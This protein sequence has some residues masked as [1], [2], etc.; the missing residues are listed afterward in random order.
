LTE[1]REHDVTPS[2]AHAPV[3]L[4]A[5][6]DALSLAPNDVVLDCTF[7]RGGHTRAM[8][9]KL[10]PT[11][12]VYA[13]DRD[14]DAVAHGERVKREDPRLEIAHC[15]FSDL[16]GAL[17]TLG[18][19]H[20]N[21]ILFDLGVSSPQLDDGTRGFSFVRNGPLDMRMDPSRGQSAEEWLAH[22]SLRDLTLTLTNLGEERFA[23]RIASAIVRARAETA[24]TTT[25]ELA[26][27]VAAA[28]PKREV[29]K[30]P[31]TRSFQ[32]I[33]MVVNDEL[34]QLRSGLEGA[35]ECLAVGGRIAAISF[36]SLEDRIVK[37]FMREHHRGP[38]LPRGLP[39]PADWPQP[40]LVAVAKPVKAGAAEVAA[41]PRARSAILRVC[42]KHGS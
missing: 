28:V 27:I 2:Q 31:A 3:L 9:A 4:R 36:H 7:G 20:V 1:R 26:D 37:H 6:V 17:D 30:H 11:G 25:G 10:G 18:V 22:V 13:L 38:E 23:R 34:G 5:A 32:A 14:P 42:R 15:A 21:A 12:R 41:N 35:L 39:A 40:E 24:I 33:R 19:A 29:S 8:L 16:K